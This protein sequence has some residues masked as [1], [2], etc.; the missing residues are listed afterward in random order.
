MS[1]RTIFRRAC[2]WLALAPFLASAHAACPPSLPP[3]SAAQMAAAERQDRGF[4]WSVERDGRTSYLYGTL[5]VGKP[6]W[7][8]PGPRVSEALAA[9]D[10][11]ALEIDPG[12]PGVQA[13]L[14]AG[15][16]RAPVKL[17][18]PLKARLARQVQAACVPAAAVAGLSAAM[19]A[20]MLGVLEAR[21]AGL[22][23]GFA[24][25]QALAQRAR[26]DG[27]EV[28]A[29]ET[30]AL[31]KKVLVPE[32]ESEALA[33]IDS[34]LAEL[35]SGSGRRMI[36]R[37][38]RAWERS[39]LATIAGYERWCECARTAAERAA[40]RALNDDRNPGLAE[41]I[42]ALHAGG[43]RVFAAVGSLH[44]TGP[45]GLPR[46]LEARGFRVERVAF[47]P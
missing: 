33:M 38:A 43:Q 28:V 20:V 4:L 12:D 23:P 27:R 35:E 1:W 36:A 10:V 22:D 32:S 7:M 3:A 16:D 26:D 25:E 47:G 30:V 11:V 9:S 41:R 46:L 2:R 45:K 17:P 5:H 42:E 21:W 44:M 15:D 24:Q 18:P 8:R 13:E 40:L 19:Q 6:T 14:L 29:L 37:L 31:Q 39:D 34:S